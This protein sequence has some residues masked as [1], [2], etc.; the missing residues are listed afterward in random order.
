[1]HIRRSRLTRRFCCARSDLTHSVTPAE[2]R[3]YQRVAAA[4]F[5]Q[6]AEANSDERIDVLTLDCEG[7]A[8]T[9]RHVE[10]RARLE[11]CRMCHS[12]PSSRGRERMQVRVGRVR[13]DRVEC[14][15]HRAPRD[16]D[17]SANFS[18]NFSA[19]F[20]GTDAL[21]HAR[22]GRAAPGGDTRDA[23]PPLAIA[24]AVRQ[25]LRADVQTSR[26]QVLPSRS[27]LVPRPRP[28]QRH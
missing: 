4:Q 21:R 28:L 22:A 20:L 19:Q 23:Y 2:L 14:G 27:G 6:L 18:A 25:F 9:S 10:M 13:A 5:G 7:C 8:G 12:K 16:G 26:I 15:G 3:I 11:Q 17:R 24:R 1:M